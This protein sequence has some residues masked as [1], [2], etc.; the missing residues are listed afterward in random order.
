MATLDDLL[1]VFERQ[2]IKE[3][4]LKIDCEGSE[5]KVIAGGKKFI[6]TIDVPYISMEVL[7]V[8]SYADL[9]GNLAYT[10]NTLMI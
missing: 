10:K 6:S 8:K 5:S 2:G 9:N 4:D 7:V 1:S 3:A